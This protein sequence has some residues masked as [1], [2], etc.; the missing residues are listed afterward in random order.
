MAELFLCPPVEDLQRFSLGQMSEAEAEDLER[1]LAGCP[2]CVARVQTVQPHDRL[3]DAVAVV[4]RDAAPPAPAPEEGLL[5]AL[6][7]L[8]QDFGN[9]PTEATPSFRSDAGT[10]PPAPASLPKRDGGEDA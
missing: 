3:L 6:Y 9:R 1:H 10:P 4:V 7:R 5:S 2:R 8:P